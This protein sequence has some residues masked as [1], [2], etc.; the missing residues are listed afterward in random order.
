[1]FGGEHADFPLEPRAGEVLANFLVEQRLPTILDLSLLRKHQMI[2]FMVGLAETLFH[3]NRQP[4]MVMIDETH[5][6]APQIIPGRT[7]GDAA[8]CLGAVLDLATLARKKGI[9]VTLIAQRPALVSTTLRT[10]VENL[11]L[12]RTIGKHDRKA[13]RRM[14]RGQG[15]SRRTESHDAGPGELAERH[16]LLLEPGLVARVP[17]SRLPVAG[18]LSPIRSR[19][20]ATGSVSRRTI[21]GPAGI[22][23]C[24]A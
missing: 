20:L 19:F 3:R 8:R 17:Q 1:M 18:D 5:I 12:L 15:I 7:E 13:N 16:R 23:T 9:G 24:S 11:I 10:Q 22:R 14:G 4:L 2:T 6:F 21:N